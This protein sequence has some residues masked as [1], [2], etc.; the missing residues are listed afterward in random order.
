VHI[1]IDVLRINLPERIEH[2]RVLM[3][4]GEFSTQG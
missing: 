2:R 4:L 3:E 1:P